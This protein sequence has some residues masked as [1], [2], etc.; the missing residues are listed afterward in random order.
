MM[1]IRGARIVKTI[2]ELKTK[3]MSEKGKYP[4]CE[5]LA[6]ASDE[7]RT[8]MTFLDN[9]KP[10]LAEWQQLDGIDVMYPIRNRDELVL[11]YLGIDTKEL[12]K[13]RRAIL[14]TIRG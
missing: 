10:E 6:A 11:E 9:I 13:E 4:N 7:Y 3:E 1:L 8:I 14:E 5:K 2:Q 12:E